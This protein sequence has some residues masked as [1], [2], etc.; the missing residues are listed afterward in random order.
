MYSFEQSYSFLVYVPL[1]FAFHQKLHQEL[2]ILWIVSTHISNGI[3]LRV[4]LLKLQG[5]RNLNQQVDA[6]KESILQILWYKL[7]IKGF[8]CMKKIKIILQQTRFSVTSLQFTLGTVG[9][10]PV[11]VT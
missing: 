2:Y 10:I 3:D 6:I 4:V 5:I 11:Y 1:V 8:N 9:F 7:W